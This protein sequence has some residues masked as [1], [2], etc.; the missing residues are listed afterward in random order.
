MKKGIQDIKN[1]HLHSL[2]KENM[3]ERINAHMIE[4]PLKAIPRIASPWSVFFVQMKSYKYAYSLIIVLGVMFA[5]V[6]VI[7]ASER[8]LPGD[9]LYPIKINVTEKV[10]SAMAFTPKAKAKAE[11]DKII[12]RLDEVQALAEKGEFKNGKR[13][14]VE[15]EVQK[16]V[17]AI[18]ATKQKNRK[19]ISGPANKIIE[20]NKKNEDEDADFEKKINTRFEEIRKVDT[21]LDKNEVKKFEERVKEKLLKKMSYDEKDVKK[22]RIDL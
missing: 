17:Q 4:N 9:A 21:T 12:K 22:A 8:A 20:I 3:F 6:G 11:E 7:D 1:I 14:Q 16:T 19:N 13:D 10:K 2:E 15:K 18:V 5:G